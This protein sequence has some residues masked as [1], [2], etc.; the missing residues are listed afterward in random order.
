MPVLFRC[1]LRRRIVREPRLI[2]LAQ[3]ILTISGDP[4]AELSLEIVGNTRIPNFRVYLSLQ[5]IRQTQVFR[6]NAAGFDTIGGGQKDK[7]I[8]SLL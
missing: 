5:A 3:E 6:D 2:S 4:E 1:R 8:T 7:V